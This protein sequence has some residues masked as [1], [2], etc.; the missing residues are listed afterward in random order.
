MAVCTGMA[1]PAQA[2]VV[3]QPGSGWPA[4]QA[5]IF[6]QIAWHGAIC[7]G[8]GLGYNTYTQ[9]A[10]GMTEAR[11]ELA[12]LAQETGADLAA[13]TAM[14]E[15][16][17]VEFEALFRIVLPL[18]ESTGE[19]PAPFAGL[20]RSGQSDCQ[21]TER[22]R[23]VL[24]AEVNRGSL[25][26][27]ALAD[28]LRAVLLPDPDVAYR[29]PRV[30][31]LVQAMLDALDAGTPISDDLLSVYAVFTNNAPLPEMVPGMA[32]RP[33]V[34]AY[35]AVRGAEP[36]VADITQAELVVVVQ[37]ILDAPAGQST[38]HYMDIF[39]ANTPYGAEDLIV[40]PWSS[41]NPQPTAEAIVA[42]AMRD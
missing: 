8:Y 14:A 39:I 33:S 35:R 12:A 9:D 3:P 19:A 42:E 10:A 20:L 28:P 7:G 13:L 30:T 26:D 21:D 6:G 1:M 29:A 27:T 16:R 34:L 5:E 41:G 15:T 2:Q 31:F 4:S 23:N 25:P 32:T 36:I 37:R 18:H 40:G 17:A 24:T 11:M 22:M 38:R